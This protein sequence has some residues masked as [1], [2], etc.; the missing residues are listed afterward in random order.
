MSSGYVDRSGMESR[1]QKNGRIAGRARLGHG[2][3]WLSLWSCSGSPPEASWKGEGKYFRVCLSCFLLFYTVPSGSERPSEA[4]KT[5]GQL[6]IENVEVQWRVAA[7]GPG[8]SAWCGR[9]Y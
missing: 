8:I 4:Q 9:G 1:S 5:Y 3:M 2:H 7:C 6:R